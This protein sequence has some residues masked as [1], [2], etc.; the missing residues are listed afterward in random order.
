MSK[1]ADIDLILDRLAGGLCDDPELMLDVRSE[2]A[3]H[4]ESA[5]EEYASQGVPDDEAFER[6]IAQFGSVAEVADGLTLAN[7]RRVGRRGVAR[8]VAQRLL[9]PVAVCMAV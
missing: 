2:L 3:C 7:R 9:V 6:V 1:Q 5:M 4:F 8:V